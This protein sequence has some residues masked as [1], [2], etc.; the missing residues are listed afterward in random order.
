MCEAAGTS[1]T[2]RPGEVNPEAVAQAVRRLLDEPSFAVASQRAA[3][4][5]AAMPSPAETVNTLHTLF[6]T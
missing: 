3:A 6:V 2:L 4:E 1:L 5:I